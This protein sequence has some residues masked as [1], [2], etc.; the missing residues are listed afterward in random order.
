MKILLADDDC[1]I[2]DL[3][4]IVSEEA[5]YRFCSA[6]NG[7]HALEVFFR[8]QPDF[9]ILDVAMPKMTGYE[10]CSAI[11][12][13]GASVPVLFLSAKGDIVDKKV[14]YG[15]GADD[16]MTKPFNGEELMLHVEALLRRC[17]CSQTCQ[18]RTTEDAFSIGAFSFDKKRYEILK[19]GEKVDLSPKEFSILML[20]AEHHG[21]VF[22][23][24]DIVRDVWGE[25]Y[26]SGSVSV[27]VYIRHIR[28]KIEDDPSHPAFLR[29]VGRVGY[30]FGD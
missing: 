23:R 28:E 8:E 17:G 16:Y 21:E 30:R 13:S 19:N 22:T 2:V 1:A 24:T 15:I 11:R 18:N 3:V 20:L 9:V 10:V 25:E 5:G 6:E 26:L 29:T 7:R 12:E 27:A 14:G 4:R